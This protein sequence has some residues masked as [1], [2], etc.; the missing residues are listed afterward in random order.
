MSTFINLSCVSSGEVND[1]KPSIRYVY[2]P[3]ITF[4]HKF[5]QFIFG[6]LY[7]TIVEQPGEVYTV[8]EFLLKFSE[9]YIIENET[10]YLK[11]HVS[12]YMHGGTIEN[13]FFNNLFDL[14]KFVESNIMLSPLLIYKK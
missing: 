13:L 11:P 2:S 5:L 3:P 1:K 7:P 12:L 4:K 6:T 14:E 8:E 9:E 10:V